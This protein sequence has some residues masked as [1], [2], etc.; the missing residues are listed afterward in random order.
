M[1]EKNTIIENQQFRRCLSVF[2]KV[3]Y[4]RLVDIINVISTRL[5]NDSKG[6]LKENKEVADYL[7]DA[8]YHLEMATNDLH[9]AEKKLKK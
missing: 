1:D 2:S 4:L 9:L 3:N 8:I 7:R 6:N 5:R